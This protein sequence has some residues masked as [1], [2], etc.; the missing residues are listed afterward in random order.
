[1]SNIPQTIDGTPIRE[2]VSTAVARGWARFPAIRLEPAAV[3]V[4]VEPAQS[5]EPAP[6]PLVACRICGRLMAQASAEWG[7]I[8]PYAGGKPHEPLRPKEAA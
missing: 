7:T 1:M 6:E 5:Q 4:E 2:I 3:S 8:C